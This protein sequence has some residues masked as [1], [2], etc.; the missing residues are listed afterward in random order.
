MGV[1]HAVPTR[2]SNME[3]HSDYR[4]SPLIEL[5]SFIEDSR[6]FFECNPKNSFHLRLIFG[7]LQCNKKN[8]NIVNHS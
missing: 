1:M 4:K 6:M 3:W 8:V 2:R 7:I 5:P